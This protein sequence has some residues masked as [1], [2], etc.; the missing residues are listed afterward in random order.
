MAWMSHEKPTPSTPNE[1]FALRFPQQVKTYGS[2]FLEQVERRLDSARKIK[3]IAPNLDFFAAIL[4]GDSGIGHQVVYL[5]GEMN[6]YFYDPKDHLYK[7]V[8]DDKLGNLI[9]GYL[10]RCAEQMPEDCDKMNLFYFFRGDK[11]VRNIVHRAKSIL[12]A[13]DSFFS[14]ES[15]HKRQRENDHDIYERVAR[16]FVEQAIERQAGEALSLNQAYVH[17]CE[18]L[19]QR[20][21]PKVKRHEFKNLVPPMIREEFD[22]GIRNDLEKECGGSSGW[23]GI[24]ALKLAITEDEDETEPAKATVSS[25]V[26]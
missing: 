5:E 3:P 24:R 18:F 26:P 8:S 17:F 12:A 9:R 2:P 1:W 20:H 21:L 19:K 25:D 10:I 23:K 6:F 22:L 13:H 7:S 16:A 4:G 14:K 11:L 15:G